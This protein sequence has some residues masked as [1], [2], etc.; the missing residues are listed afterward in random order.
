[1]SQGQGTRLGWECWECQRTGTK[2]KGIRMVAIP[3]N[4]KPPELP[5]C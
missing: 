2:E 5:S 4:L 3:E 1:M